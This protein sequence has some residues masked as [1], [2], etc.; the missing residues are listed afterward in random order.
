[1]RRKRQLVL[2][3][4]SL[5]LGLPA[6]ARGTNS[7]PNVL[8]V[9][10]DDMGYGDL[11]CYGEKRVHTDNIDRLAREGI[12][13]TQF[14]VNCPIC[15]PSRTALLTG[16]YPARW[17]IT[18]YLASRAENRDRGM[19]QWLD[20]AAPTLA[21]QLKA[22]GYATGH[23]GKWHMGGQRDV[24]DAPLISEYGFEKT[25]TTFEGLGDRVLPMLDA[26][27]G[28][29]AKK[30][31][32]GSDKLGRG[33]ITWVDRSQVTTS[34]VGAAMEFI[35]QAEKQGRPFYV[36]VWPDDVHSPFF[37]PKSLR[38]DG[39]KKELYLGVVQ[40][41][42]DQLEPLLDYVRSD[43]KL[44]DNTLIVVASDNG[45][46]PGAGSAGP[47][48]GH[49]GN[50][51]EGGVREPLIVWGPGLLPRSAVGTTNTQTVVAGVD[52]LPSILA[53]TGAHPQPG[54]RMDGEDMSASLLG[55]EHGRRD[56]PLFWLRPPDRPGPVN[57]P[58]PDLSVRDGDWK[59]LINEDGSS[60][61]LYDLS[62]DIGEKHNLAEQ[63]TEI[64][65]RL[66][67][68]VADW[69]KSLPIEKVSPKAEGARVDVR[70]DPG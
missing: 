36:N 38:G 48:R 46:E 63:Q 22:A 23:F 11:T 65:E 28:M 53:I 56:K 60:P 18:S 30:Y 43:P 29:P 44:R 14:Y 68:M 21:R 58:F 20:P 9:L 8:F 35:K 4:L 13:F 61:Q 64:V 54:K 42:D 17:K 47:F 39:S 50:L 57:D 66:K 33:N 1:M 59:L 45:P 32:L 62:K 67:K 27:D 19:A 52:F 31:S 3:V 10:I 37:P 40:A 51:Y 25:L 41:T 5:L 34:F 6:L 69:R 24:G 12:R 15:S 49:K 55:H 70:D 7:R 26:Y 2:A 16:Q